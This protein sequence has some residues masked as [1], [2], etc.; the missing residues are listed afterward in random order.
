M[1]H[2]TTRILL[3]ISCAL[4]FLIPA[5]S[6]SAEQ[7][8]QQGLI[9][10]ITPP[11]AVIKDEIEKKDA[12]Y[13]DVFYEPSDVLQGTQT[14]HWSELTTLFGYI[15]QNAS[16]YFSVSQFERF[17]KK[18]FTANFGTYI[19]LKDS[20]VHTEVGFGWMVD[21]IYRFV[22]VAEYGHK[23]YRTLYWQLGYTYKEYPIYDTHTVYPGLIYYFG[24]SYMSANWGI[25]YMES[26]DTAQ[27]GVIKGNFAITKYL[28]W[29]CGVAFGERLYDINSFDARFEK[30][31]ILFTGF[32][33]N[34]YKGINL[35]LGYSYGEEAPK[36]IKRSLNFGASVKF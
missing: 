33:L 34:L 4:L 31:F 5:S 7:A 32:N 24:D 13:F 6:Y 3:L 1:L 36:F 14:G 2:K 9:R 30:G 18:D 29:N 25:G 35:K 20:Y 16:A 26:N 23:L 15:H 17:D 12:Y 19:N 21:Y 28:Q 10:R 27:F 8:D 11:L 22:S